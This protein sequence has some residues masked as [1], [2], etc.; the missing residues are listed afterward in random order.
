MKQI[1]AIFCSLIT[2]FFS[3]ISYAEEQIEPPEG[4]FET[5]RQTGNA[6]VAEIANPLTIKLEDGRFI[7]LAGLD[8][9]D[10]DYYSPGPLAVTA[11]EIL[12]DFLTGKNITLYQTR[13]PDEGRMNRLGH[14]IAHVVRSD[15]DIWVQGLLL[16]L[17]V[18]RVRTT[19][20]NPDMAEQML[21]LEK[22]A[23]TLKNGIW[24]MDKYKI[25]S[26]TDAENH[27]GS[28]QI[29]EGDIVSAS[30]YRNILYLNFGQNYRND[31]T[32]SLSSDLLRQFS[33]EQMNPQ[34]WNGQ[35]IRV[36]GWIESY[37]GPYIEATHAEQFELLFQ[38]G[39]DKQVSSPH[40]AKKGPADK[41]QETDNALP[42]Y[43][44]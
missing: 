42:A 39:A 10:L 31:F 28:Y 44:Q 24:D 13:N 43:N 20:Y 27:I 1:V 40:E 3:L 35:R 25:L 19:P 37:N 14:H 9:P 33:Y 29:V 2:L 23:R 38:E 17:G 16:S 11:Q 7:H 8:Y 4:N 6:T 22:K 32:V 41:P 12:E 36:R 21:K 15:D 18:G 30:M 5:M 26:P 34:T